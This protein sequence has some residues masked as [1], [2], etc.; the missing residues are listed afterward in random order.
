MAH[1]CRNTRR[2]LTTPGPVG[3]Y[4]LF[5]L[6][7]VGMAPMLVKIGVVGAVGAVGVVG[8][9]GTDVTGPGSSSS[10]DACITQESKDRVRLCQPETTRV[11]AFSL[12]T[13]ANVENG[14]PQEQ[15]RLLGE[16]LTDKSSNTSTMLLECVYTRNAVLYA[17]EAL[18]DEHDSYWKTGLVPSGG[19]KPHHLCPG[20]LCA[21]GSLEQAILCGMHHIKKLGRNSGSA[22]DHMV[23]FHMDRASETTKI[24]A[25]YQFRGRLVNLA[26]REEHRASSIVLYVLPQGVRDSFASLPK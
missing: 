11:G 22:S 7:D 16:M 13:G 2:A 18:L 25:T 4:D 10:S 24:D 3:D 19:F 23:R 8:V 1:V 5:V 15:S 21:L 14:P 20:A 26:I 17:S 12:D 6:A 9:V